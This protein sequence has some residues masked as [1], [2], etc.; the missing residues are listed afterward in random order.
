MENETKG[1]AT[2]GPYPRTVCR[3]CSLVSVRGPNYSRDYPATRYVIT[4]KPQPRTTY[5]VSPEIE[6]V[7]VRC[8]SLNDGANHYAIHV[9]LDDSRIVADARHADL[10]VEEWHT[11][12]N[13]DV[14]DEHT[15]GKQWKLDL[16]GWG[17]LWPEHAKEV[18]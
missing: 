7:M 9:P 18:R 13:L 17:V 5:I 15:I 10:R 2:V 16:S 8:V 6:R 11:E 14:C 4:L 1:G 12:A 3:T